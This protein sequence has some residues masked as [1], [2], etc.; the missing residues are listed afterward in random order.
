[1][2]NYEFD[3]KLLAHC[4][5]FDDFYKIMMASGDVEFIDRE[6]TVYYKVGNYYVKGRFDALFRN[7]KTGKW[8]IIDWKSSGSIDTMPK[9]YTGNLLGPAKIYKD[10]NWYTYTTQLYFYKTAL[11]E[12]N[13]LKDTTDY[14]DVDVRIVNLP[15]HDFEDGNPYC[16]YSPAYHYNKDFL[17]SVFE[18]AVKKKILLKKKNI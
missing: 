12:S 11:L 17:D 8:I 1:M 9:K 10:L 13:M 5:S 4:N 3:E 15:D 16:S 6:K 18:F 14:K 2:S 7:N